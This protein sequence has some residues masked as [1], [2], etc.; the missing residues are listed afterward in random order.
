MDAAS[1]KGASVDPSAGPS[2]GP[3][4]PKE[5]FAQMLLGLGRH[6]WEARFPKCLAARSERQ[7]H[8]GLYKLRRNNYV[9][10]LKLG[11]KPHERDRE[12]AKMPTFTLHNLREHRFPPANTWLSGGFSVC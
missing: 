9:R 4:A 8:K 12:L 7:R 1:S 3:S 6:D 5:I 11:L 2:A 10:F